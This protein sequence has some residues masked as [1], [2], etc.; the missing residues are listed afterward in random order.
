MTGKNYRVRTVAI[1]SAA[2]GLAAVGWLPSGAR[3]QAAGDRTAQHN[4]AGDQTA[5]NG[6][7]SATE[8]TLQEVVVTAEKRATNIQTTPISMIALS[9]NT[10]EAQ[11]QT[12]S[13]R[14]EPGSLRP[15]GLGGVR[16]VPEFD[17]SRRPGA[18]R[19]RKHVLLDLLSLLDAS[20]LRA[21]LW[22]GW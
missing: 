13:G 6:Q 17:L 18:C 19:S 22:M 1:L 15:A 10:L 21:Q 7:N 4:A 20:A 5:Q 14:T 9:G 16:R 3:A 2:A 11:N 8:G 12:E